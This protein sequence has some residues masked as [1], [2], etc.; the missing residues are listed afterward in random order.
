M[1]VFPYGCIVTL[2][3]IDGGVG[4]GGGWRYHSGRH[5]FLISLDKLFYAIDQGNAPGFRQCRIMC[6]LHF[7]SVSIV[8][9]ALFQC[10]LLCILH[11]GSVGTVC[12]AFWQC[13]ILCIPHPHDPGSVEYRVYY[14]MAVWVLCIPHS[15]SVEYRVYYI[16]AV[17]AYTVYIVV[18]V[19][20]YICQSE[21]GAFE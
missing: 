12:A 9:T 18:S 1:N 17:W 21:M 6:I 5:S 10:G 19:E 14:I 11:S 16:M 13:G 3:V 20:K 4:R 7:G 2:W 8:Y 15:G